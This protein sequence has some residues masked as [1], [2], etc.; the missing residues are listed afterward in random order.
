MRFRCFQWFW[1][2]YFYLYLGTNHICII[3]YIKTLYVVNITRMADSEN[4]TVHFQYKISCIHTNVTVIGIIIYVII[5]FIHSHRD[6]RWQRF[7]K[8]RNW[9]RQARPWQPCKSRWTLLSLVVYMY[10]MKFM[11]FL[12]NAKL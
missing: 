9:T 7:Y 5:D 1:K 4:T 12:L 6:V 11:P 2:Y 3:K 10:W 8:N